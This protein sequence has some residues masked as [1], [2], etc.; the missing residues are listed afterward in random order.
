MCESNHINTKHSSMTPNRKADSIIGYRYIS[1]QTHNTLAA[2]GLPIGFS[3]LI[4][5]GSTVP[6][7]AGLY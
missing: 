3:T 1:L 2:G 4:C 6:S 5:E 7:V